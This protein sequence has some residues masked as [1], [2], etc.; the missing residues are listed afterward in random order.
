MPSPYLGKMQNILEESLDIRLQHINTTSEREQ[1][2]LRKEQ[3]HILRD[4]SS[5]HSRRVVLDDR[6]L[7]I[8]LGEIT[9][10]SPPLLPLPQK[11]FICFRGRGPKWLSI[12][13]TAESPAV[14]IRVRPSTPKRSVVRRSTCCICPA[15]STFIMERIIRE[16]GSQCQ[17]APLGC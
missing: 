9:N 8:P 3:C 11:I 12:A 15:V 16:S 7:G 1:A 6:S 13:A 5:E 14:S 4:D 17:T 2:H 10:P